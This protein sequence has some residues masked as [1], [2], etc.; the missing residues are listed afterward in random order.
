MSYEL[1]DQYLSHACA[2]SVFLEI[3]NIIQNADTLFIQNYVTSK[4][5]LFQ[6]IGWMLLNVNTFI[7]ALIWNMSNRKRH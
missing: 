7:Y 1:S 6:F 4:E 3:L 5:R 2:I